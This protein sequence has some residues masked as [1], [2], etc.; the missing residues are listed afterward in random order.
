MDW[1]IMVYIEPSFP[2][3]LLQP[4]EIKEVARCGQLSPQRERE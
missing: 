2:P 3:D 4:P 1:G